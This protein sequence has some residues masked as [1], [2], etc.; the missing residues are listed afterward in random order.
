[1][2]T[3][4][5]FDF[6]PNL[7]ATTSFD[8]SIATTFKRTITATV[9]DNTRELALSE[10]GQQYKVT[11][12]RYSVAKL[13]EARE[14]LAMIHTLA[15]DFAAEVEQLCKISVTDHECVRFLDVHVPRVDGRTGE[16]LTGRSLTMA[17]NKRDV[18]QK[19]Y[20]HDNR[21]APWAGTGHGVIQA[22]NTA[23]HHEGTVRGASR[24]ERNMLRTVTGDFGDVDRST[25]AGLSR[26]LQQA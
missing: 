4:E 24:A 19:L 20:R 17:D 22:V 10:R 2:S 7:L 21:V 11:H 25:W 12:S 3:P 13:A 9:C 15:E 26:V 14:A 18:L 23:E 16:R 5:G 8:G 1:M 6:R